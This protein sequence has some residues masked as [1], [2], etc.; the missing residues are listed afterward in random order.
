MFFEFSTNHKY[1]D[2]TQSTSYGIDQEGK[3]YV[4]TIIDMPGD[5][6]EIPRIGFNMIFEGQLQKAAWFGRGPEENYWDR[7]SASFVGIHEALV[8]DLPTPYL[9]P[10]ENSNRSDVRWFEIKNENAT[11]IRFESDSL[12]N[13]SLFPFHYKQLEHY[14]K[15][16]NRHGSEIL[17][18]DITYLNVDHLQMGVGGDNS[19]GAKTHEKYTIRPGRYEYSFTISPIN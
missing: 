11:G 19:W 3:V 8:R 1:L 10:Q 13:F 6:P 18:E 5:L 16:F 15:D 2:Y 12:M 4:H 17:A 7:K 9:R 14:S